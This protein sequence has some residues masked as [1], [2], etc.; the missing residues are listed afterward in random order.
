MRYYLSMLQLSSPEAFRFRF[1][2]GCASFSVGALLL[3]ALGAGCTRGPS[4]PECPPTGKAQ[5]T[6]VHIGPTVQNPIII[7]WVDRALGHSSE[8]QLLRTRM[9]E[10]GFPFAPSPS[11]YITATDSSGAPLVGFSYNNYKRDLRKSVVLVGLYPANVSREDVRP[12]YMYMK[13]TDH[14]TNRISTYWVDESFVRVCNTETLQQP[15][16]SRD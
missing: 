10:H 13:E 16:G 15:S 6:N 11:N 14:T 5:P 9:T 7:A 12:V 8:F 1:S 3:I 2:R 4:T